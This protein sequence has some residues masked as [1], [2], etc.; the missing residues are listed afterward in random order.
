MPSIEC[1]E[2]FETLLMIAQ[3]P[4]LDYSSLHA[5]VTRLSKAI[6]E[7]SSQGLSDLQAAHE[8]LMNELRPKSGLGFTTI[9]QYYAIQMASLIQIG[10]VRPSL[11]LSGPLRVSLLTNQCMYLG[12]ARTRY[13]PALAV[14]R[15]KE[16]FELA[17][18][19]VPEPSHT[20]AAFG[21]IDSK[22]DEVCS[23]AEG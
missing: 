6:T 1:P 3:G 22:P 8:S 15:R 23:V 9:W 16:M 5:L 10:L 19:F 20:A 18:S 4:S 12:G 14:E 2:I 11:K 17:V 13:S 21:F 7:P